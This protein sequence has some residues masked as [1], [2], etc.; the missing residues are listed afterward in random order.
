MGSS[1]HR[2]GFQRTHKTCAIRYIR[3]SVRN[4]FWYVREPVSPSAF[5][6][7]GPGKSYVSWGVIPFISDNFP[8]TSNIFRQLT[9]PFTF[10]VALE[11]CL[12]P[13]QL[14]H[15]SKADVDQ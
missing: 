12:V 15:S 9:V 2:C 4:H 14:V 5:R 11:H 8:P 3:H 6:S 13:H 10:Y 7:C 1:K